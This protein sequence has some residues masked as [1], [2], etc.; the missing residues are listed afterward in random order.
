[1]GQA[2]EAILLE[3]STT[4]LHGEP[5]SPPQGE[6]SE[7][8]RRVFFWILLNLGAPLDDWL[9]S[10]G[11]YY[12]AYLPWSHTTHKCLLKNPHIN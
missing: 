12:T 3:E 7:G 9:A 5:C 4:I 11:S 10:E 2:L 6:S 8:N 1:M